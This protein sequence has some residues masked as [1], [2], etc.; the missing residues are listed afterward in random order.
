MRN[1][2]KETIINLGLNNKTI[3]DVLWCGSD[4]FG[5]FSW[6]EF[7]ELADTDYDN[8]FGG[9]EVAFDLLI[10]GKDYWLE[11]H[12][13]DGS[14]WWESKEIPTKPSLHRKPLALT[15]RQRIKSEHNT[16]GDDLLDINGIEGN[17]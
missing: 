7:A 13:Y 9:N 11:R 15:T 8:G 1:L 2:L 6:A 5:W 17:I 16:Y 4:A 10:V 3:E 12:E 14:E